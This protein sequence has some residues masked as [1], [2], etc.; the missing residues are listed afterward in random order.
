MLFDLAL[1][2]KSPETASQM[3]QVIQGLIALGSLGQPEDK[4][5]TTIMQSLKVWA[6]DNVVGVSLQL[7]VE[8]FIQ[9]LA[10]RTEKEALTNTPAS[11]K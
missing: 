5:I 10:K 3:Q 7:P 2:A 8:L 9:E 4:N 6:R 1:R 11:M